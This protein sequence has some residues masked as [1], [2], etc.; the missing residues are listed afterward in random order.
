M[1]FSSLG[2][3]LVIGGLVIPGFLVL[4]CIFLES[5]SISLTPP[6]QPRVSEEQDAFKAEGRSV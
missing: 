6:Q 4:G 1:S 5:L 3:S 2:T